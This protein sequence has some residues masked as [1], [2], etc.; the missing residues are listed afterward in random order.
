MLLTALMIPALTERV[1]AEV[2]GKL[3][4]SLRDRFEHGVDPRS[5]AWEF[6]KAAR[7]CERGGYRPW[8]TP[9][10]V[11]GPRGVFWS[12]DHFRRGKA[13]GLASSAYSLGISARV[14]SPFHCAQRRN[15]LRPHDPLAMRILR[16]VG[17]GSTRG[18]REPPAGSA[19]CGFWRNV[20]EPL[21]DRAGEVSIVEAS[22]SGALQLELFRYVQC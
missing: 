15:Q 22:G 3:R 18:Q 2:T 13:T 5:Q 17:C 20:T 12:E 9:P 21:R 11:T 6:A 4:C 14:S 10:P 16:I 8:C 19:V 1:R 7:R